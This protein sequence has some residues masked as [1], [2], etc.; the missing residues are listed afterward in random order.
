MELYYFKLYSMTANILSCV[1]IV[2]FFSSATIPFFA[3]S[4]R[5]SFFHLMQIV[6]IAPSI[7]GIRFKMKTNY[8]EINIGNM[9]TWCKY[10]CWEC[11]RERLL[12][13][14]HHASAEY[15]LSMSDIVKMA[16]SSYW[17]YVR[18]VILWYPHTYNHRER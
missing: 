16:N 15:L 6:W 11:K 1:H 8:E 9:F 2:F 12:V 5:T 4:L 14:C 18:A 17:N 13:C 10:V 7:E 3:D